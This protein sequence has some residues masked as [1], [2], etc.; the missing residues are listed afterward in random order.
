[1]Q[2]DGA[3]KLLELEIESKVYGSQA[4]APVEILRDTALHLEVGSFVSLFGPSG[5]GKTSILRIAAGLDCDFRGKRWVAPSARIGMVF[6]EP[7]L[8]A[9]RTVED[10]IRIA[11][12]AA[13]VAGDIGEWLE[14]FDLVPNRRQ[15]AG[16]LSLGQ[17]RRVAMIRAL[18]IAP[19]LLLLDE[20]LVSLD[21]AVA[22]RIR[23]ELRAIAETGK[24]GILLVTHDLNE[25]VE[26]SDRL[27]FLGERSRRV[28]LEEEVPIPRNQRD[29]KT[30]S[31]L[32]EEL[33]AL[34]VQRN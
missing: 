11:M 9:W 26:L 33:A 30:V 15:F 2:T 21:G 17:A 19:N 1:M 5:C 32:A 7:R 3:E 12:E 29:R 14:R 6:Q 27:L 10:N 23:R 31:A 25:A 18:S 4:G 28:V 22:A 8:L 34:V 20:P 16:E 24:V 13:D